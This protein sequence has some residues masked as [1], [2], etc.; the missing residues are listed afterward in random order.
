MN[1]LFQVTKGFK[2]GENIIRFFFSHFKKNVPAAE[3]RMREE[4]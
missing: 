2:Q 4:T 3:W 1:V